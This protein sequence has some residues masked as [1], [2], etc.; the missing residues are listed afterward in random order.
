MKVDIPDH[1]NIIL[2]LGEYNCFTNFELALEAF[3]ILQQ[4]MKDM[5]LRKST[6]MV[7]LGDELVLEDEQLRYF[8][9]LEGMASKYGI[10]KNVYFLKISPY[11]SKQIIMKIAL[12]VVFTNTGGCYE[13]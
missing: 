3:R 2:A 5:F 7:F 8:K 6:V 4:R 13:K 1:V 10:K 9:K 11:I 12:A